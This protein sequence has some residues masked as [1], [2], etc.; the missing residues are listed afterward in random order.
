[1]RYD[2][3]VI[4]SGP[5]GQKGAIAAAKLHKRV[6]IVERQTDGMGGVCLHTG[7]IP[8]KT[9]REAILYLTGYRQR[10][11]YADA[12]RR[13]RQVTMSEL[14]RKLD[15]VTQ[16]E[17]DVVQDQLQRNRVDTYSGRAAVRRP[18]RSRGDLRRRF[19]D[20]ARGEHPDRLRH[21]ARPA[22]AT[23]RSTAS[24]FSTR[25]NC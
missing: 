2:L 9:M 23:S 8:S 15:Q 6:A 5:A 16:H 17:M 18:A 3:L 11:V 1:M 10:E 21:E 25:M 4:G 19:A 24:T 22:R 7:T 20:P 12:Y 14:A 13:K